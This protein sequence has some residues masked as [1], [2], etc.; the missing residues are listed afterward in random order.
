MSFNDNLASRGQSVPQRIYSTIRS[1]P[2]VF[3]YLFLTSGIVIVVF[4][5]VRPALKQA[6]AIVRI[7]GQREQP[8]FQAG[9][10]IPEQLPENA[11]YDPSRARAQEIL[12]RV[13]N[14]I[15]NEPAQSSRLLQSWIRS[16]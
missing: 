8:A 4:F 15:K 1:F 5:G 2:E 3:R 13:T 12:D 10:Q 7:A 9:N 16:E 11:L 14:E 6:L